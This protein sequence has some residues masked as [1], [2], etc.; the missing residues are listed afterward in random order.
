[1]PSNLQGA[2]AARDHRRTVSLL[3]GPLYEE[4]FAMNDAVLNLVRTRSLADQIAD[5]I[6]E[7]IA[8]GAIKPGQKIIEVEL[9]SQLQVSRVPVREALKILEAQGIVESRPHRGVRVV[10]FDSRKIAQIY[11]VRI[12]L[13]KLAIRDACN[14]V[15]N[16]SGLLA[17]LDATIEQMDQC[18]ARGD[19]MGV[20]KADMQFHHEICIAAE[21]RIVLI[22]W[23]TLS[24]H[25]L[26]IFEQELM[27]DTDS[28]HIVDHHRALR[29]A[30]KHRDMN[31]LEHELEQHILRIQGADPEAR[32]SASRAS[33]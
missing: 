28:A 10:D 26:I 17:R 20:S 19:L 12:F 22:L 14:D 9:A 2:V 18:L 11:E 32:H 30:L 21:N 27:G 33:P 25:M 3:T 4:R 13:E 31:R 1:M 15:Q 24:R 29:D 5:S 7:G 8:A 16:M 6:V 23:E